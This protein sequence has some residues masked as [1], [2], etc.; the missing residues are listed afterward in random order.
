MSTTSLRTDKLIFGLSLLLFVSFQSVCMHGDGAA[1][2]AD[3]STDLSLLL[4][5]KAK[6]SDHEA[7]KKPYIET[8]FSPGV[9]PTLI[10]FIR[11]EEKGIKGACYR[12]THYDV[13]RALVKKS[14]KNIPVDLVVDK[15]FQ[16]DFCDSLA[17]LRKND[18][19]V[20]CNTP[21]RTDSGGHEIMHHKF[22]IFEQNGGRKLLWTGSFNVTGQANKNNWEN[23][24]VMDDKDAIKKFEEQFGV[25]KKY[26][27]LIPLAQCS[28][29]GSK[30]KSGYAKRMNAIP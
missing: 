23:V 13:A 15:G 20:L 9:I 14:K 10:T 8:F 3:A 11:R 17:L 26:A 16:D 12:L 18:V 29:K 19:P 27:A 2:A 7:E 28:Y 4:A 22:F 24:V 1:S 5:D 6:I 25:L 21:R 30:A